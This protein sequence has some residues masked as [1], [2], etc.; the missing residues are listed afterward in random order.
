MRWIQGVSDEIFW[1]DAVNRTRSLTS[2]VGGPFVS[3]QGLRTRPGGGYC[4]KD[5]VEIVLEGLNDH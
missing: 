1:V 3:L 2:E 4:M 5:K